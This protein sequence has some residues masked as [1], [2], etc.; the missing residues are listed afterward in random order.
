MRYVRMIGQTKPGK[1]IGKK[2]MSRIFQPYQLVGALK[3]FLSGAG[4]DTLTVFDLEKHVPI[5][6]FSMAAGWTR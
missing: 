3:A 6:Y 4:N 1:W 5:V 2:N